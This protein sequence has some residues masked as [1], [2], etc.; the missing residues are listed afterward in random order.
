MKKNFIVSLFVITFSYSANAFQLFTQCH[1]D[2]FYGECRVE[3]DTQSVIRCQL[4]ILGQTRS[5]A[6]FQGMINAD[7]Y[8]GQNAYAYVNANNGYIDPLVRVDGSARCQNL[9]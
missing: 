8:P 9:Y 4:K 1:F 2:P 5:G 3:N 6:S 7:L